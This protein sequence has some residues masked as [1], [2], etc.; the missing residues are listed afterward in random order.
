VS[1]YLLS[2]LHEAGCPLRR[3]RTEIFVWW[4]PRAA[5]FLYGGFRCSNGSPGAPAWRL[6]A[7][8]LQDQRHPVRPSPGGCS[9]TVLFRSPLC[10]ISPVGRPTSTRARRRRWSRS[11]RWAP[12]TAGLCLA[13]RLAGRLFSTALMPAVEGGCSLVLAILSMTLGNVV[14]LAQTSIEAHAGLQ[15]GGPGRLP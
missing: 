1:S 14:A 7:W 12:K 3:G 6:L 11:F 9:A 15:L 10:A 13:L 8:P 2:G 4:V 5:V